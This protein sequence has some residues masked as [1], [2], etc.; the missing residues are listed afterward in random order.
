MKIRIEEGKN[1]IG[2]RKI[3]ISIFLILI[4][5]LGLQFLN[6]NVLGIKNEYPV[7]YCSE[8]RAT[9]AWIQSGK[10]IGYGYKFPESYTMQNFNDVV[11]DY[12][13]PNGIIFVWDS[14][15]IHCQNQIKDFGDAWEDYIDSDLTMECNRLK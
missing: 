15:C 12:L 5:A 3:A 8:I 13:I 14:K 10:I 6:I 7:D 11:N 1:K 9:P 4:V 2:W